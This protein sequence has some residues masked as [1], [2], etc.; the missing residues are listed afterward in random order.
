MALQGIWRNNNFSLKASVVMS[1]FGRLLVEIAC[2]RSTIAARFGALLFVLAIVA[3]PLIFL[4]LSRGF[5]QAP[6]FVR[7][8]VPSVLCLVWIVSANGLRKFLKGDQLSNYLKSD[9]ALRSV[10]NLSTE[11]PVRWALAA[12]DVAVLS[13]VAAMAFWASGR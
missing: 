4:Q 9:A 6:P 13:T 2:G 11:A 7:Y 5:D 1:S 8:I 3:V 10:G 12:F